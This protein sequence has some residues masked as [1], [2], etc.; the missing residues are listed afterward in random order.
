MAWLAAEIPVTVP[1]QK[2][3]TILETLNM[4]NLYP[5]PQKNMHTH[6]CKHKMKIK[7]LRKDSPLQLYNYEE[8]R[9]AVS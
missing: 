1:L 6:V 3:T 2:V 8:K 5:P 9:K 7:M 4:A